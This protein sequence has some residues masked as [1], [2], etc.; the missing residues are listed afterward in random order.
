MWRAAIDFF[1]LA[2]TLKAA[3]DSKEW[4]DISWGE[5]KSEYYL[6]D[7]QVEAIQSGADQ[8]VPS[9]TQEV[10]HALIIASSGVVPFK[11]QEL[12]LN[13]S[14]SSTNRAWRDRRWDE[15]AFSR[16][17]W[18]VSPDECYSTL[19]TY[20]DFNPKHRDFLIGSENLYDTKVLPF[21]LKARNADEI[22][23]KLCRNALEA[24]ISMHTRNMHYGWSEHEY[25]PVFYERVRYFWYMFALYEG[26]AN[27]RFCQNCS[28]PFISK[29][30]DQKYCGNDCKTAYN[31]RRRQSSVYLHDLYL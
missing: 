22:L 9:P 21:N 3:Q 11:Y 19:S 2:F 13:D 6:S 25:K 26:K 28:R 30:K 29:R 31:K 15:Q 16:N 4:Q 10:T 8:L 1:K 24:L 18:S 27:M 17:E 23:G 20:L 14:F 12:I 7:E 5:F